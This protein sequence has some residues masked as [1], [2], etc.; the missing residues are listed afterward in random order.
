M[1]FIYI[2]NPNKKTAKK[3]RE[4]L[5]EKKL[6]ACVNFF[7][8]ESSYLWQGK[9]E[10]TKEYVLLAKTKDKN[11]EKIKK[12]VEKIHPYAIPCIAKIKVSSNKKFSSWVEKELK[13]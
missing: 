8:I 9:I 10:N 11:F 6:A 4:F 13:C 7:P 3:I 5:L 2:A 1:I 12:E